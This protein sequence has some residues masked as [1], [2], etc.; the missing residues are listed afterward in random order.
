MVYVCA[1]ICSRHDGIGQ[2]LPIPSRY[3]YRSACVYQDIANILSHCRVHFEQLFVLRTRWGNQT[4]MGS[5]C[6]RA[7]ISQRTD[8]F[9]RGVGI[10]INAYLFISELFD[11]ILGVL[12]QQTG[13][14]RIKMK[15][16]I[17]ICCGSSSRQCITLC[18]WLIYNAG[19]VQ[20]YLLGTS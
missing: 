13:R 7:V 19:G 4:L 3:L 11:N 1:R 17:D 12:R 15:W 10:W 20:G 18:L 2:P 9:I 5:L 8:C 16:L 14:Y 6:R